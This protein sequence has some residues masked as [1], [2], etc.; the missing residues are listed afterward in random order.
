MKSYPG[1]VSL[2]ILDLR[3]SFVLGLLIL[4]AGSGLHVVQSKGILNVRVFGWFCM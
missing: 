2:H 3:L 4:K 1:T